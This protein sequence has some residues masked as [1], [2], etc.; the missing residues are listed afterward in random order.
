M[1]YVFCAAFE[2]SADLVKKIKGVK[3]ASISETVEK[4]K[5]GVVVVVWEISHEPYVV[6]EFSKE[7]FHIFILG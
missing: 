7:V 3:K 6:L 5:E 1:S 4:I 2:K